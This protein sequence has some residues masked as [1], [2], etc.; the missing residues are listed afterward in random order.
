MPFS[1]HEFIIVDNTA[2]KHTCNVVAY[3]SILELLCRDRNASDV[4]ITD[5]EHDV[6]EEKRLDLEVVDSAVVVFD[7]VK[8]LLLDFV[9]ELKLSKFNSARF[10]FQTIT[11]FFYF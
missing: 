2:H 4:S 1:C 5:A 7:D 6:V 9:L 10:F 3:I 8:H 11:P